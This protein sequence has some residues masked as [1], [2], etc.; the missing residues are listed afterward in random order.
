MTV[1]GD[2]VL[3]VNT[4]VNFLLLTLGARLC[5][6]PARRVRCL[7][8]ALLGGVYAVVTLFPEF[9]F[10]RTV[11]IQFAVFV[12][13]CGLSYGLRRL[14]VR[15]A[16]VAFLCSA[17]LAGV[18]F[19]VT[20]VLHIGVV[21]V[22]GAVYYPLETKILLLLAGG[23]YLAAALLAANVLRHGSGE[24]YRL[25]LFGGAHTI[26]VN[27]LYDTGA[28]LTDPISGYPVVILDG[29]RAADLL[30]LPI[31]RD[32]F[33]DPAGLLPMLAK[34][35]PQDA[36]RLVPYH[37][38]GVEDGMLLAAVCNA[39]IGKGRKRKLLAAF[40]PTPVSDGGGYEALIGGTAL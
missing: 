36:F 24:I 5:G 1:Y 9:Y 16:A 40:S 14:A 19:L 31:G 17:A 10:L 34:K 8:G 12:M 4:A 7:L 26:H 27:A 33:F 35:C 37:A 32:A 11:P 2:A 13:M 30:N 6:Y 18:A 23:F 28:T 3:G 21:T 29:S 25:S 15:A 20:D 22:C 39:K 38:V